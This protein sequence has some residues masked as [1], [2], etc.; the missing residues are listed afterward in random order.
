MPGLRQIPAH[1]TTPRLSIRECSANR[2]ALALSMQSQ[3]KLLRSHID[4]AGIHLEHPNLLR[5]RCPLRLPDP[6]TVSCRPCKFRLKRPQ[7]LFSI[8]EEGGGPIYVQAHG[9]RGGRPPRRSWLAC[10][11]LE[12]QG[13]WE[14]GGRLPADGGKR[15]RVQAPPASRRSQPHVVAGGASPSPT[16]EERDGD[17]TLQE[18]N[19][20]TD[21]MPRLMPK[22][23]DIHSILVIGS[24][25]I[26]IGQAC[27]FDY[28]GTQAVRA[29]KREGYR[30][31][32]VNSNPATIM[33]DPELA[34]ATYVEPLT[35]E[36]LEKIVEKERPDALLPTVGGQTGLNLA[37]A[38]AERGILDKWSVKLIGANER[39]MRLAE[40]RELFKEAMLEIGAE[41]PRSGRAR[42]FAEAE[43]IVRGG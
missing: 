13:G 20:P 26:V 1:R 2:S 28:S 41:V 33:T 35:P 18:Q 22:R 39:A 34:D 10:L 37:L 31:V 15:V 42:S 8:A 30:V 24:G 11:M 4:P 19:D 14:G 43:S 23:T 6:V 17:P 36:Y 3:H 12:V 29:L 32:L 40:D 16:I 9:L 21:R 38:L 27:E 5:L 7:I 25:P